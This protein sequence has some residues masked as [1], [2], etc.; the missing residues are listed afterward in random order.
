[1]KV[2]DTRS[3]EMNIITEAEAVYE[4]KTDSNAEKVKITTLT[5]LENTYTAVIGTNKGKIKGIQ[6]ERMPSKL[7]TKS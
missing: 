4:L 6:I 2:Y 7:D 5:C 3:I 1:M